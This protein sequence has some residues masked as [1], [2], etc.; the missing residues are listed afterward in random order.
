[1]KIS[2]IFN[3]VGRGIS[4][5]VNAI[6]SRMLTEHYVAPPEPVVRPRVVSP[7]KIPDAIRFLE[8]NRGLSPN[9]PRNQGRV[10]NI[11]A[12]NQ[13]EQ[14]RTVNYN[15]GYGGEYGLTPVALAELAKSQ[16]NR[17][18]N[19]KTYTKYGAPLTPGMDINSIQKELTSV[20]GAGRLSQRYFN[21]KRKNKEDFSPESLSNDY[22]DYYVGKGM[23]HDTPKN[24]KRALDYF[25]SIVD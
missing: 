24:R 14:P 25:N 13:N 7:E 12:A 9:T 20:E 6:P 15:T 1:M 16:I 2:D 11:P 4:K 10:Y 19:P 22:V 3:S 8:S 21:S 5:A 17:E 18:A 23:I